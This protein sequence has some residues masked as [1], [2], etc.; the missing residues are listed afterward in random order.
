MTYHNRTLSG[1]VMITATC[2]PCF[3]V[4]RQ[5]GADPVA[6]GHDP[7]ELNGPGGRIRP[8]PADQVHSAATQRIT[9]VKGPRARAG[10]TGA[11]PGDGGPSYIPLDKYTS[12]F[13]EIL[14]KLLG[15]LV[16]AIIYT[17]SFFYYIFKKRN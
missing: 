8:G 16:V 17:A 12:R 14:E 10:G 11:S 1:L 9:R 4:V 5:I 7:R 3:Q 2:V 13:D 6:G 15:A